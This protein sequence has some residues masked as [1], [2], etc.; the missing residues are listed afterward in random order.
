MYVMRRSRD[1]QILSD[2]LNPTI[3]N[4]V[5]SIMAIVLSID[6]YLSLSIFHVK[7]DKGSSL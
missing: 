4:K 2:Y 6:I 3:K 7:G 5:T 1:F